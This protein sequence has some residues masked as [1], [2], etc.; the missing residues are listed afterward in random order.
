MNTRIGKCDTTINFLN[1][2]RKHYLKNKKTMDKKQKE[3]YGRVFSAISDYILI[4]YQREIDENDYRD[5]DYH[6]LVKKGYIIA[7]DESGAVLNLVKKSLKYDTLKTA[8]KLCEITVDK[9]WDSALRKKDDM[10]G[11][12]FWNELVAAAYKA[13]HGLLV[14]NVSNIKVFGQCRKLMFLAKQEVPL[15]PWA[16]VSPKKAAP[17]DY[18]FNKGIVPSEVNFDGNVLIVVK[19]MSWDE[20]NAYVRKGEKYNENMFEYM[21]RFFYELVK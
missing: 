8:G 11:R 5:Y 13:N 2:T 15:V 21:M 19:D 3:H 18:E 6:S 17:I 9:T 7:D 10:Q 4:N 20:V 16:P 14:I 1:R 12:E